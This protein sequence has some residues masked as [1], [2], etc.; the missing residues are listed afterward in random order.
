MKSPYYFILLNLF[1]NKSLLV[2]VKPLQELYSPCFELRSCVIGAVNQSQANWDTQNVSFPWGMSSSHQ[3]P[4]GQPGTVVSA[5]RSLCWELFHLVLLT[6]LF[7]HYVE[8]C[9]E[10]ETHKVKT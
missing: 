1:T 2:L 7:Q 10:F 8:L 5:V 9:C 4:S 3:A 6:E